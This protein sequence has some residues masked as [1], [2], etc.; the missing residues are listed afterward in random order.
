MIFILFYLF[1]FINCCRPNCSYEC[2]TPI[3]YATCEP[4][5]LT[6]ICSACINITGSSP[7]C[8][9]TSECYINCPI[10]QCEDVSCPQCETICNEHICDNIPNCYLECMET[11]CSWEC[12]VPNIIE[13]PEPV[14]ELFCNRPACEY[15]NS[16]KNRISILLFIITIII[17]INY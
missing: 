8:S 14:C 7:V 3:C 6:P 15:S 9:H 2:S 4:I 1:T 11:Q 17:N 16:I 12:R 5:C 13:C 10:N